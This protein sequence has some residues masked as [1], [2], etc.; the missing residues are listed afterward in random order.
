ME[1]RTLLIALD[2]S[3]ASRHAA[4]EA[5]SWFATQGPEG[6]IALAAAV[7]P[8]EILGEELE[9]TLQLAEQLQ[10]PLKERLKAVAAD[11]RQLGL[12]TRTSFMIGDANQAILDAVEAYDAFLLVL[13]APL[14]DQNGR[15]ELPSSL[16]RLIGHS[17][18]D[19]LIIPEGA[20]LNFTEGGPLLAATDGSVH[21]RMA[22]S[23]GV[24]LAKLLNLPLRILAVAQVGSSAL[25]S[26]LAPQTL[27]RISE[28]AERQARQ[29]KAEARELGVEAKALVREGEASEMIALT[30][31][32][33][34]ASLILL[35]SHGRT[36]L[37]RLLLGSCTEK[38]LERATCPVFVARR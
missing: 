22:V 6:R 34:G 12:E 35:G 28:Q 29:A 37:S 30:A 27:R 17:H 20:R 15:R 31:Q 23:H 1:L 16:P 36:G 13:G 21:G 5:A 10:T 7:E 26:C 3:E 32:E 18:C 25:A 11:I 19:V 33:E 9:S 14:P 2:F 8:P 24:R 4:L 38:V